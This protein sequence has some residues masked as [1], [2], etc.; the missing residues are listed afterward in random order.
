MT[1]SEGASGRL[2][3]AGGDKERGRVRAEELA[4]KCGPC[5]R[6]RGLDS[7]FWPHPGSRAFPFA[8]FATSKTGQEIRGGGHKTHNLT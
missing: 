5:Q 7:S 4:A 8:F 1:R 2:L 3:L 6:R